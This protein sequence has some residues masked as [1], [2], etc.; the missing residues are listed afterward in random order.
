MPW[1]VQLVEP[2]IV[3]LVVEGSIPSL[4]PI[5]NFAMISLTIRVVI[6]CGCKPIRQE[7]KPTGE[8]HKPGQFCGVAGF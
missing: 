1:V 2:Q 6:L 4:R 8:K 5:K 7:R 3:A